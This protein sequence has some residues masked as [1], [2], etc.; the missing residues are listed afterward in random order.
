M[1]GSHGN[2]NRAMS[3]VFVCRGCRM[4]S[5]GPLLDFG[6]Q[7]PSN[8]FERS[9][10]GQD[11]K[12]PLIVG[13]CTNCGLMQLVEPM[14]AEMAKSRFEWLTYNEPE[15]HLDDLVARLC[16][17]PGLGQDAR[18]AG[19][20]YKDDTTLARLGRLGY[21]NTY[22]FDAAKDFGLGDP[23][24][25]LESIQAA[26][27]SATVTRLASTHGLADLLLVRHVLEHAHDPMAFLEG[28]VRLVRPGG[29]LLF[30]MPDCTKFI[31]A[32][33]FSFIWEEHITYFCSQS[34]NSFIRSAGLHLQETLVYPYPLEDSLIG[35]VRNS[36]GSQSGVS[37]P[38]NL[39]SLLSEGRRFAHRFPDIH[40]GM[41][42]LF[43]A[44]RQAG[45]RIAIFGAGHLAAK[46]LNMFSLADYVECVVDDHPRKQELL[47]PGSRVPIRGS[48]VLDAIDL[49]L[50]SLNPES[51]Q[52]VLARNQRF[53]DRGGQ[54]FSIFALSPKSVYQLKAA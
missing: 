49:C 38:G 14:P 51:E 52:R 2:V 44:W 35:I 11:D 41:K 29:Y 39:D 12:H 26:L 18:I 13:Q 21:F 53:L 19:L 1:P 7:P 43:G 33:D 40:A 45:K 9:G 31:G 46:F 3:E 37:R 24:A 23:C 30:E 6:S 4:N 50:L 5:L 25:G 28:L 10:C 34:L 22:R 36:P 17:L 42:N 8:R 48:A 15:G 27:D 54:F 16:R 32:C 20:T 47:M